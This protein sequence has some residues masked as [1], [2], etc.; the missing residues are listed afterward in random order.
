MFVGG[1]RQS[2]LSKLSVVGSCG[3][4]TFCPAGRHRGLGEHMFNRACSAFLFPSFLFSSWSIT[5][6]TLSSFLSSFFL[7]A[8]SSFL[9]FPNLLLVHSAT[10]AWSR[11][12]RESSERAWGSS[13]CGSTSWREMQ[14]RLRR[15][16]AVLLSSTRLVWV[17]V[18]LWRGVFKLGTLGTDAPII[19]LI[20]G[21]RLWGSGSSRHIFSQSGLFHQASG[22]IPYSAACGISSLSLHS[23]ESLKPDR[24]TVFKGRTYEDLI[25]CKWEKGMTCEGENTHYH[26]F[27]EDKELWVNDF[28]FS[29]VQESACPV[30]DEEE[31]GGGSFAVYSEGWDVDCGSGSGQTGLGKDLQ[32]GESSGITHSPPVQNCTQ[33]IFFPFR[34]SDI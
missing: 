15:L 34:K 14:Y 25:R 13:G 23:S 1:L 27:I 30:G 5:F 9:L 31:A 2:T 6:S 10:P 19:S 32:K 3:F 29:A 22:Y 20:S 18:C 12:P 21:I 11:P 33:S 8:L 26:P 16:R 4:L 7:G 24:G 17:C 28:C